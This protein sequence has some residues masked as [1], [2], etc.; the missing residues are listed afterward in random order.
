MRRGQENPLIEQERR[1]QRLRLAKQ[2]PTAFA[3][4]ARLR[5]AQNPLSQF[6]TARVQ[7]KC[8]GG[9]GMQSDA[10]PERWLAKIA[11]RHPAHAAPIREFSVADAVRLSAFLENGEELY[12]A[13]VDWSAEQVQ[14]IVSMIDVGQRLE[15]QRLPDFASR[16]SRPPSV[17]FCPL[18]G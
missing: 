12:G 10:R 4:A 18:R 9:Q 1:L 6:E 5:G 11:Q 16:R 17:H 15:Q 13:D 3:F 2:F 7:A 14:H 8:I